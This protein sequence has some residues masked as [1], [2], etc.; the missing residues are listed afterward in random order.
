[1]QLQPLQGDVWPE[2]LSFL[3]Q[4]LHA[5]ESLG[6]QKNRV[7]VDPG[8]GFG[9]TPEQNVALLAQQE[10]I[11][12]LGTG[13]LVGWS[14]KSTLGLLVGD[15]GSQADPALVAPSRRLASAA[16]ALIAVQRGAH[17]VRVHEV[18]DTRDVLR[19]WQAVA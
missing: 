17:I 19:V 15:G 3:K 4:Q 9:K 13:L 11:L 8:V 1:M 7:V 2:V 18:R 16:A 6:I 5:L 10:R 12:E 14:R